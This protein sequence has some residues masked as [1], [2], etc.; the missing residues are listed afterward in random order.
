ML[1]MLWEDR[2]VVVN[3]VRCHFERALLH[4]FC[5]LRS[6]IASPTHNL[7]LQVSFAEYATVTV[8][9]NAAKP[10]VSLA[11]VPRSVALANTFMP[12]D[13]GTSSRFCVN[14]TVST[15]SLAAMRFLG[16]HWLLQL[17]PHGAS[18][19]VVR[20]AV[21]NAIK[22]AHTLHHRVCVGVTGVTERDAFTK[23]A[24]GA[25][26]R[27]PF[28][29]RCAP[30]P[31][32]FVGAFIR[33]VAARFL[34]G[35]AAQRYRL[36]VEDAISSVA[37]NYGACGAHALAHLLR[38]LFSPASIHAQLPLVARVRQLAAAAIPKHNKVRQPFA[39]V[40]EHYPVDLG[41]L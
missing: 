17:S 8:P 9:N 30:S 19:C 36:T 25:A 37:I 31:H 15:V 32:V 18:S 26:A 16:R 10:P 3:T 34:C 22:D 13:A 38:C 14:P 6:L 23:R 2:I 39:S 41:A 20:A 40:A 11:L 1:Y 24:C 29:L 27:A 35:H 33:V 21:V 5:V 7:V 28:L 4:H 12:E